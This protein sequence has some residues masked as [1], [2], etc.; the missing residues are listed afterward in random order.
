M[1]QTPNAQQAEVYRLFNQGQQQLAQKQFQA[2][3]Q[4]YLQALNLSR[5]IKEFYPEGSLLGQIGITYLYLRDYTKAIE[6][7]R[8]SL[9]IFEKTNG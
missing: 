5:R 6:Y 2:A 9:I 1:A 3:L 7:T 4:S 8:Q